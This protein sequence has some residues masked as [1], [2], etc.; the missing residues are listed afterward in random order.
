MGFG[1]RLTPS[2]FAFHWMMISAS[3]FGVS[4]RFSQ[5]F[6]NRAII[7]E[8]QVLWLFLV[9]CV[10]ARFIG[11]LFMEIIACSQ[12]HVDDPAVDSSGCRPS[13]L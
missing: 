13:A 7:L 11:S 1:C 5:I 10:V 2:I 6:F 3:L 9:F 12:D 4:H 8:A